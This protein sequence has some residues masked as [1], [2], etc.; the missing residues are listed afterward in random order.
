MVRCIENKQVKRGPVCKVFE[1]NG[2]M[3][4][5]HVFFWTPYLN[6]IV[7]VKD[8]RVLRV[9]YA[10]DLRSWAQKAPSSVEITYGGGGVGNGKCGDSSLRS[11]C[12]MGEGGV[13]K[14]PG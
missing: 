9:G 3:G 2:F 14:C 13:A 6:R 1:P 11:E 8:W 12:Q 5:R 4:R 10:Q 7:G